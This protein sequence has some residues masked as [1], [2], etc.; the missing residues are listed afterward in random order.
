ML[1]DLKKLIKYDLQQ[2]KE[3]QNNEEREGPERLHSATTFSS[4]IRS[5]PQNGIILSCS[6]E[7]RKSRNPLTIR[8]IHSAPNLPT[9]TTEVRPLRRACSCVREP[10]NPE[11]LSKESKVTTTTSNNCE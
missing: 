1:L 5:K 11:T 9:R 2:K 6:R 10:K 3:N 7:C 8:N 4:R